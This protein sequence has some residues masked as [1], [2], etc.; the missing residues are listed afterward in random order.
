MAGFVN[1]MGVG[2]GE[3]PGIL[4]DIQVSTWRNGSGREDAI[5]FLKLILIP[6]LEN[7][8]SLLLNDI[9]LSMGLPSLTYHVLPY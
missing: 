7:D 2:A 5:T 4:D 6:T 1:G 8:L 9:S 3:K